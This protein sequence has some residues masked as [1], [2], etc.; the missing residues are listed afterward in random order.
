MRGMPPRY[1]CVEC[2]LREEG[3]SGWIFLIAVA[4]LVAMIVVISTMGPAR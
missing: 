4:A 3:D 2:R 1:H